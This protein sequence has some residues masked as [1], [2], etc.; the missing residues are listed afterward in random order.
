MAWIS[1]LRGA[2]WLFIAS[3]GVHTLDH[4]RRGLTASP[5]TV[6]WSGTMVALLACVAVTLVI[7]RHAFAPVLSVA[8]FPSVALG[9]AATHL[10][11]EWGPLSD[12]ILFDSSS[13]VWSIPA[14]GLEIMAAAWLGVVALRIVRRHGFSSEIPA[15]RWAGALAA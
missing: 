4:L 11:P 6:T 3:W 1:S 9:V 7:T 8:V 2:A 15:E 5:E 14:V 10:L 13:D 12:P